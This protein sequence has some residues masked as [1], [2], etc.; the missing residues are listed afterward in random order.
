MSGHRLGYGRWAGYVDVEVIA[1]RNSTRDEIV[2]MAR[3]GI[4]FE[5][6]RTRVTNLTFGQWAVRFYA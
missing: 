4:K 1:K 5:P 3:P 6:R 2:A